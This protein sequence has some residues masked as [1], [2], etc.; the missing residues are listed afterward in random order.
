M[1]PGLARVSRERVLRNEEMRKR[2]HAALGVMGLEHV[3]L[4]AISA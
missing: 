1:V 3:T 2:S 4:A